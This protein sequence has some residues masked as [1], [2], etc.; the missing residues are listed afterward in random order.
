MICVTYCLV[1]YQN[2]RHYLY[3]LIIFV[4]LVVKTLDSK[5]IGNSKLSTTFYP[6]NINEVEMYTYNNTMTRDEY[7]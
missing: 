6:G 7:N 5:L 2:V 4:F 1:S 3:L